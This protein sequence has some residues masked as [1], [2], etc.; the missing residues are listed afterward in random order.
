MPPKRGRRETRADLQ[1]EDTV[2]VQM[3]RRRQRGLEVNLF[4]GSLHFTLA[5][6]F[7]FRLCVL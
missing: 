2:A 1:P 6:H 5:K 3:T 4:V 7:R